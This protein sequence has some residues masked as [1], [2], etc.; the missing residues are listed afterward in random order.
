MRHRPALRSRVAITTAVVLLGA[1]SSAPGVAVAQGS[2]A[3]V[4]VRA[5]V[6]DVTVAG[7]PCEVQADL[8]TP[9]TATATSPAAAILTTNGFGGSKADQ[10]DIGRGFGAL[11]YVVLSYS[12]LGF[13]GSS[14]PITL[15]DRAHDGAAASQLAQWLGGSRTVPA[16]DATSGA[17]VVVDNV[18]RQDVASGLP[19]DPAVGMIGGSYGGEVQ[20]AAA[21]VDRRIDTLI[22]LITWN[23]LAFS[24]APNGAN[25][26]PSSVSY[27][28]SAPGVSKFEWST[29]FFALG[30]GVGL[31]NAQA[32]VAR[33]LTT[34]PNFEQNACRS[35]AQL[36]AQGYPDPTTV[37]YARSKSVASYLDAVKV[38]VLLGQGQADTLFTLQEAVATY[39]ALR[40]R[41]VPVAMQ[42]QSWGHSRSKPR[43][44][45]LDLA[46]PM[47]TYQGRVFAAWFDHYLRGAG[48]TPPLDFSYYRPWADTTGNAADAYTSAPSYPV[49]TPATLHLS[50]T[51]ALV[52]NPADVAP[53]SST[54]VAPPGGVAASYTETSGIDQAQPVRDAP[55]TFGQWS[56]APLSAPVD[57]VGSPKLTVQ[58]DAPSATASQASGPAGQLVL[59]AK[60]YDIAPDGTITLPNRVIAPVRVPD[61][62]QPVT[63]ELPALVHR[64]PA[65]HRIALTLATTDAAY[66]N[67]AV[68]AAVTVAAGAGQTLSLPTSGTTTVPTVAAPAAPAAPSNAPTVP[69][70]ASPVAAAPQAGGSAGVAAQAGLPPLAATSA[71]YQPA[72]LVAAG[73]ALVLVGSVLVAAVPR[74]RG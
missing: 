7:G 39:D 27:P 34:C 22:P 41:N 62:T 49:A 53:G 72:P 12:G 8:Y 11:G 73:G 42:W 15:D 58:L 64:V 44:G 48:P 71:A 38:P 17:A 29:L 43:P 4:T 47:T 23:D 3:P 19:N 63:I 20:F 55:G 9:S 32:D 18:V 54:F 74:R 31:Q 51:N 28:D 57:L 60:L 50:G 35:K 30:F 61:V 33:L 66:R 59:F 13:G 5:I 6:L 26:P 37:A 56:T 45:E 36:D 69:A 25:L 1:L 67:S 14:C 10:A 40:A 21:A 2:P 52:A 70:A 65:G 46:N 68:P 16:R 24:L